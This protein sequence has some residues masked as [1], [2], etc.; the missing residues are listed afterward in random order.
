MPIGNE[1]ER[2]YVSY[3]IL[4]SVA[5]R[6]VRK[7]LGKNGRTTFKVSRIPLEQ[8]SQHNTAPASNYTFQVPEARSVERPNGSSSIYLEPNSRVKGNQ[9]QSNILGNVMERPTG[10][11]KRTSGVITRIALWLS[12]SQG[13]RGDVDS[14]IVVG[15]ATKRISHIGQDRSYRRRA[16]VHDA[17]GMFKMHRSLG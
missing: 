6:F 7:L 10:G 11:H 2:R 8:H 9:L 13:N 15:C 1:F 16:V 5:G 3:S 17:V 14:D 4:F 12:L